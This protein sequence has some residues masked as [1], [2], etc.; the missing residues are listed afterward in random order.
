MSYTDTIAGD[1]VIEELTEVIGKVTPHNFSPT[2][3]AK[4]IGLDIE[5]GLALLQVAENTDSWGKA[6]N[7]AN[8]D[9]IGTL[10]TDHIP[11][12]WNAFFY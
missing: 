9:A 4:L 11:Y 2:C 10:Y 8:K 12:V 6:T 3:R 1:M 7:E 5:S